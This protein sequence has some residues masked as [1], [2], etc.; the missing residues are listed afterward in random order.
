MHLEELLQRRPDLWRGR[1]IATTSPAGVASGFPELDG[2]LPWRGWPPTGLVEI[3][4]ARAGDGSLALVM[5]ALAALSREGP[6]VLLINPPYLPYAPALA[7]QGVELA[8][9]L[10]LPVAQPS[11]AAWAA[12]QGLRSGACRAVLIWGGTWQ[13][14]SLRRLQLAAE[15]GRALAWLFRSPSAAAETSPAPLRLQLRAHRS[16]LRVQILKQRGG[17]IAPPFDLW[18]WAI[19]RPPAPHPIL[20]PLG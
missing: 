4:S 18:P 14:A 2:R 20:G 13:T 12:E 16:G 10:L 1:E 3:L 15:T 8:R 7:W 5:P 6:W 19:D 11:E 17:S 9:L